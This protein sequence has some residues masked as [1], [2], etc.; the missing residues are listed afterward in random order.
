MGTLSAA[1]WSAI[2]VPR[3]EKPDRGSHTGGVAGPL[4]DAGGRVAWGRVTVKQFILNLTQFGYFFTKTSPARPGPDRLYRLRAPHASIERWQFENVWKSACGA[5]SGNR[6]QAISVTQARCGATS[7]YPYVLANFTRLFSRCR[8]PQE[9][10]STPPSG[11][12]FRRSGHGP[13]CAHLRRR[14]S[15]TPRRMDY[16]CSRQAA[17]RLY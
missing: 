9:R 7:A 1:N 12:A 14:S 16:G 11:G 6:K 13:P 3:L 17:R 4:R 2:F 5:R 15:V 10:A 8:A